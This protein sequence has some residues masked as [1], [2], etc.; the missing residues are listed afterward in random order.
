M[1][2]TISKVIAIIF[3]ILL[4]L[5]IVLPI[6]FRGR[7]VEMV[8]T[9]VDESVEAQ[10]SFGDF[11]LSLIRNFPNLSVTV[12]D[13]RVV[14]ITEFENDTL[15]DIGQLSL[16]FDLMSLFG[17]D[18]YQVKS[19]TLDEPRLLL[20]VLPEGTAN[21]DIVAT[22]PDDQPQEQEEPFR[23]TLQK[24]AINNGNLV[25][26]DDL[27]TTYITVNGL[28][29]VLRGDLSADFTTLATRNATIEEFSLRYETMPILTRVGVELTAEMDADLEDF[30]FTFRENELLLNELPVR[31]DGMI[32]MPDD[33]IQMDFTFGA[34][35][36]QFRHFL[37]LIPAVY[38]TDFEQLTT[39]GTLQLEGFVKGIYNDDQVP[40]FGI[41]LVVDEG[42]FQYPDLPAAVADVNIVAS[43]SNPGQ[44]IDLTVIDVPVFTMNMGGQ[45]FEA[46]LNLATPVSDPQIDAMVSGMIDLGQVYT[47]YPLGEEVTLSGVINSDLE[48]RGRLSALETEQYQ[49][50]YAE[51]SLLVNDLEYVSPDF[52]Q[53]VQV[54]VA[55][56]QFSPRFLALRAF[57]MRMGDSDLSAT[58]RIDNM[59]GYL[60]DDQLLTGTFQARS[61]F[62][63]LNQLMEETPQDTV[64]DEPMELSV[65]Q[66]PENIDFSLDTD[67][68]RILFGDLNIRD[69]SGRIHVVDQQVLL[70]DMLMHLLG[71]SLIL[72]GTYS[73]REAV[74]QAD[75]SMDVRQFDIQQAF[76]QF[77]T[78][79][80]LAPIGQYANG[81]ISAT[82]SLNTLLSDS[83][84]PI[85]SS[86][87]GSGTLRSS[88][89]QVQNTPAMNQL[90]NQTNLDIFREMALRDLN[91][92]F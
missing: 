35:E 57:E 49:D 45:P 33:D 5:I 24:V 52:A 88:D 76:N 17:D 82:L 8:R 16:T 42:M 62:F 73:T 56:F 71:G 53:G 51:G 55:D 43:I 36:S 12:D 9:Q 34:P 50:F 84:M 77:N 7:I 22:D 27:L 72:N 61:D 44:D 25:Y 87:A 11:S 26:H 21:W 23:L 14:G 70:Q 38:A 29:A 67:F 65:I 60:L 15:A 37:S 13:I 1:L 78:I 20:R 28:N 10:V 83:L 64:A 90:A 54:A 86:L 69:A 92:S 32:G 68:E 40:A 75:F 66:V 18:P 89:V 79:Q 47:F 39:S 3:G 19:I 6:A 46:R 58:G 74:P 63:N 59:L 85:L 31:F 80:A 4:I 2:K 91:L 81:A 48:A 30:I 41:D